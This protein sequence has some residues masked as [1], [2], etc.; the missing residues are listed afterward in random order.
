MQNHQPAHAAVPMPAA[1]ISHRVAKCRELEELQKLEREV[2]ELE[3][4]QAQLNKVLE[5]MM[6]AKAQKMDQGSV[7][8]T[9]SQL[10]EVLVRALSWMKMLHREPYAAAVPVADTKASGLTPLM[11]QL[12]SKL[13]LKTGRWMDLAARA[14]AA[15]QGS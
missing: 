7:Q 1:A 3:R 10:A 4:V 13:E 9:S 15:G 6:G 12:S 14:E 5:E 11:W 8:Q 2:D